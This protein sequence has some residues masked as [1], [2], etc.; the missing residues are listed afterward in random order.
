MSF[1]PNIPPPPFPGD[2]R[3]AEA[4]GKKLAAGLCAILIGTLGIHKFILGYTGAG[5]TMLLVSVLTCGLGAVV[6][7]VIAIVEGILYLTKSDQEFYQVYMLN[8]KE[9]F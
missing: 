2:P 3:L 5:L 7:H 8:R 6:M 1:D 4:S 9:W